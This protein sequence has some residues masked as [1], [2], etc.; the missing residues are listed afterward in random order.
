MTPF[1]KFNSMCRGDNN[2]CETLGIGSEK[3]LMN[4]RRWRLCW[5]NSPCH[6]ALDMENRFNAGCHIALEMDVGYGEPS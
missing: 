6:I 2:A 4:T 5:I 3:G 1:G